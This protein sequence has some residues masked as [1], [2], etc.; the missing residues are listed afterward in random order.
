MALKRRPLSALTA[1]LAAWL[2]AT[3]AFAQGY[4]NPP[5]YAT[6]T[7]LVQPGTTVN[8][9]VVNAYNPNNLNVL[10]NGAITTWNITFP[11]PPFD[12]E[13]I[14][15]GC[16]KGS[17]GTINLSAHSPTTVASGGPTSCTTGSGILAQYQYSANYDIWLL[18]NFSPG[19]SGG[20]GSGITALTGDV[21]ASGSGSVAATLATV[22]ANTGSFGD[23]T[24]VGAYT[25][26][27]KGLITAAGNVAITFPISS[28]TAGGSGALTI[29]PT[30]GAV[31]ADC[32]TATSIQIGCVK[33]DGTIITVSAGAITV[34]KAAASTF[35]VMESGTGLTAT[36]GVITPTFGT[37]T[38][39]VAQGG[40]ITAGGPIGSSTTVPVITFN[41]AGQLTAVTTATVSGS[42]TVTSVATGAGLSGGPITTTGTIN[43]L[44]EPGTISNCILAG[45]VS[46]GAL[47]IALQVPGGGN[48]SSTNP[49][50]V[51]FRNATAAT[52]DY[53]AVLVTAATTF[54]TGTLGSTFGSSNGVPFRL[55]ITAWNNAGTVV[56]GVSDQSSSA[57]VSPIN[58]AAVQSSTACSACTSAATLGTFYTTAA[59]SSKAIRILGYMDWASGLTTAGTWASG[60]TTIQLMGP[61][62]HKPGDI[63]QSAQASSSASVTSSSST[64]LLASP[65]VS[66]APTSAVDPI[67]ISGSVDFEAGG[68]S[69]SC[70]VQISRSTT[71]T[72]TNLFN[73]AA[74]QP[75]A[76]TFLAGASIMAVDLPGTTAA[77]TYVPF[78]WA[79]NSGPCVFNGTVTAISP[80]SFLRAE[81]IMGA[82]EPVNDNL[83]AE[84]A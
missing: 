41:A 29:S 6:G 52:G 70:A 4:I 48:P 11:F 73:V 58:E 53:T 36:A 68:S 31:V 24:H 80:M 28:I 51:S 15:I 16:P 57:G 67:S 1:S 65:S 2:L 20:G 74:A 37:A 22:N 66:L 83:L 71:F 49:C 76:A 34:P 72:A 38:G 40:Q 9:T 63:V 82:L 56:I 39:Q 25:V 30:T 69:V 78:I 77:T 50:V 10:S 26:N 8:T 14:S 17:V 54:S 42:G 21:T 64:K 84:A 44:F 61:G 60:P 12:G 7:I 27:A 35:G 5:V 47:T 33:P 19:G 43:L 13:I 79:G 45:T 3:A 18:L 62:V 23:A 75:A 59:Q 55:W 81:E 32:T 46:A